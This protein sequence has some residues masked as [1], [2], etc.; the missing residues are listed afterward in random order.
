MN[1]LEISVS[2]AIT[3]ILSCMAVASWHSLREA[4]QE[5]VITHAL[6]QSLYFAREQAVLR[7]EPI[8][9]IPNHSQWQEGWT[10]QTASNK[11][12]KIIRS[13]PSLPVPILFI[14]F[15]KNHPFIKVSTDSTTDGYQGHFEYGR[16]KFFINRGGRNRVENQ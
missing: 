9:I 15:Q 16:K 12:K 11:T 13:Y 5:F 10:L 1:L 3:A 2:L 6:E 7:Y 8:I 14:H 4:Q